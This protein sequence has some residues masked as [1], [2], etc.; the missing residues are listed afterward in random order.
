MRSISNGNHL[1]KLLETSSDPSSGR[2]T[3]STRPE[4]TKFL[5]KTIIV[6]HR[7]GGRGSC[8]SRRLRCCCTLLESGRKSERLRAGGRGTGG[9]TGGQLSFQVGI[10][11]G[12]K[13]RR[14]DPL[15]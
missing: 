13:G 14:S 6:A 2:L 4:G 3:P 1:R 5:H 10:G 15:R 12:V 11:R 7:G 8:S 9:A